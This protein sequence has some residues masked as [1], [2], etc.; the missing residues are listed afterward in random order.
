MKTKDEVL[1]AMDIVE[2]YRASVMVTQAEKRL[3]KAFQII[4]K[5]CS[6]RT[7]VEPFGFEG[8]IMHKCENKKHQFVGAMYTVCSA[9]LC[10]H[11]RD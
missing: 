1:S 2:F 5:D 8:E 7:T 11:G 6:L 4:S 9:E 3:T 10:P